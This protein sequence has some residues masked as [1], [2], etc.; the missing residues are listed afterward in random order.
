VGATLPS[1]TL[2][3]WSVIMVAA[4]TALGWVIDF[5]DENLFSRDTW[6]LHRFGK[7]VLNQHTLLFETRQPI[8]APRTSAITHQVSWVWISGSEPMLWLCRSE[9]Q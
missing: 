2:Q 1:V 4:P 8:F 5:C 9:N 6:P 7:L 3:C